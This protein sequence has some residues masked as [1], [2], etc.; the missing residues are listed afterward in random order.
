MELVSTVVIALCVIV[1]GRAVLATCALF[2]GPASMLLFVLALVQGAA[3]VRSVR[4]KTPVARIEASRNI[5]ALVAEL[6]AIVAVLT[7]ASW[8]VGATIAAVEFALILEVMR[9]LANSAKE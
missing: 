2:A 7:Q 3:L 6:F 4:R 1:G 5:T 8:S 9:L